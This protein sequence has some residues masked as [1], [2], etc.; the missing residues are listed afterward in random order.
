MKYKIEFNTKK[1]LQKL[2]NFL[3]NFSNKEKLKKLIEKEL[4]KK[5]IKI[6]SRKAKGR[7]LQKWVCDRIAK[8][9]DIIYD[10]SDDRGLIH[11]REMGQSGVDIILRGEIYEKFKFDIECKR[12]ESLNLYKAIEQAKQNNEIGRDWLIVHKK[13][14]NK[15]VVIFSWEA[16]EK[17]IKKILY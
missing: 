16:F 6:S 17:L 3:N 9:F 15:P 7:N 4:N 14:K 10:Q 11:S 1:E 13:N 5:P 12:T 8:I 2:F